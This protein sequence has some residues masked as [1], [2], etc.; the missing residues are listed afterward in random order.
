MLEILLVGYKNTEQADLEVKRH[1]E[2]LGYR[3]RTY[4]EKPEFSQSIDI[5]SA[6][7]GVE[8]IVNMGKVIAKNS[9]FHE[10]ICKVAGDI[11]AT[12][13]RRPDQEKNPRVI[14]LAGYKNTDSED[15]K[16]KEYFE[17]QG[18]KVMTYNKL[19]GFAE[20]TDIYFAVRNGVDE[21][22]NMAKKTPD[23]DFHKLCAKIAGQYGATLSRR[24]RI[25]R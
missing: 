15:E 18:H 5:C 24:P 19:D 12:V 16:I 4:N 21:V 6:A 11:G 23:G 1:F 7:S 9:K 22:V 10:L 17:Q 2:K 8:E 3:V 13:S 25:E 14:L 20:S